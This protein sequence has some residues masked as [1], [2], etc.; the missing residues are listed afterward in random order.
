MVPVLAGV[1]YPSD[2]DAGADLGKKIAEQV[3]A[4]AKTDGSDAVWMGSV[5]TGPCSWKA[6]IR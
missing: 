1:Q 3:I 6:R 5:P 4:K 2:H